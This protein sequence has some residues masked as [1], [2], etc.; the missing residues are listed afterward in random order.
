MKY[1]YLMQMEGMD[2][3]KI[4]HSKNPNKRLESVQ[5]GN[6]FKLTLVDFYETQRASQIEAAM[7]NRYA[8]QKISENE[9]KLMGEWFK[10]DNEA[11]LK[12]RE[13]CQQMDANFQAIEDISTLFD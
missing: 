7:H 5:T 1:V 10:L 13:I 9:Y 11:I 12:F 4:G 2:I 3:Y 6:P 8:A